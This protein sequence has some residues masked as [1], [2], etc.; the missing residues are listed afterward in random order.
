MS[1]SSS[2]SS[3]SAAAATVTVT[4]RD[5]EFSNYNSSTGKWGNAVLTMMIEDTNTPDNLNLEVYDEKV[6]AV[7]RNHDDPT[8]IIQTSAEIDGMDFRVTISTPMVASGKY[9]L[10][11][12][13]GET[14]HAEYA[15]S[16]QFYI[17]VP[18]KVWDFADD[19][20]EE[21]VELVSDWN[22][23]GYIKD[24]N[25]NI[26]GIT[27][28]SE[29]KDAVVSQNDAT[30]FS[31]DGTTLTRQQVKGFKMTSMVDTDLR[32]S[33][34]QNPNFLRGY[35]SLEELDIVSSKV[36]VLMRS[37]NDNFNY[38]NSTSHYNSCYG[39]S[40][41]NFNQKF[42]YPSTLNYAI[43]ET[44]T[45]VS[46]SAQFNKPVYLGDNITIVNN[47]LYGH[48][49][50]TIFN[51]KIRFSP[52]L[53]RIVGGFFG[54]CSNLHLDTV[55]P[56]SNNVQ[57]YDISDYW[58][59]LGYAH[60]HSYFNIPSTWTYVPSNFIK[61]WNSYDYDINVPEGITEIHSGAISNLALSQS[62]TRTITLPSTLTSCSGLEN[63]GRTTHGVIIDLSKCN[64][65]TSLNSTFNWTG[66]K[67]IKWPTQIRFSSLPNTFMYFGTRCFDVDPNTNT[68]TFEVP[69]GITRIGNQ[70]CRQ[71]QYSNGDA[72]TVHNI[73]LPSTLTYI[74]ASF[75]NWWYNTFQAKSRKMCIDMTKIDPDNITIVDN[76]DW[77]GIRTGGGFCMDSNDH[78]SHPGYLTVKVAPGTIEKWQEKLPDVVYEYPSW[79]NTSIFSRIIT[80]VETP[81]PYGYVFYRETS[82]GPE[83][84]VELQSLAEFNS[85]CFTNY[86]QTVTVGED[87]ITLKNSAAPNMITGFSIGTDITSLPD[88]FGENCRITKVYFQPS[89]NTVTAGDSCFFNSGWDNNHTATINLNN[90]VTTI[91]NDFLNQHHYVSALKGFGGVTSVGGS[92]LIYNNLD[93]T[94]D[95][96]SLV[97]VGSN[98]LYNCAN[99]N[100]QLD[101][102]S[103]TT[104][105]GSF[106]ERCTSYNQPLSLPNVTSGQMGYFL[107]GC[108]SFNQPLDLSNAT[109]IMYWSSF[110]SGCTSFN[111]AITFPSSVSGSGYKS[112]SNF[113]WNCT[114]FNQPIDLSFLQSANQADILNDCTV[115]NS[116]ITLP[117]S[118]R[119]YT[120][121]NNCV[122]FN[123]PLTLPTHTESGIYGSICKNLKSF[124]Q[125][126]TI[127]ST[128]CRTRWYNSATLFENCDSLTSTVTISSSTVPNGTDTAVIYKSFSTTDSTAPCYTTGV[129]FTGTGASAWKNVLPDYDGTQ[130]T[131]ADTYRKINVV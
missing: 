81:T 17:Q 89:A 68:T 18:G 37:Y 21:D 83:K 98:F 65:L 5:I 102:S 2:S 8:D 96:S 58:G 129:T 11:K 91:G 66:I 53:S 128:L 103:L 49:N 118:M 92:F 79:A 130:A 56:L 108:T 51:S 16:S 67:E 131:P 64:N 24:V 88:N 52:N 84:Y 69:E 127:P 114:S 1:S 44:N 73:I 123:Q 9:E 80:W 99:F 71:C 27:S 101:F 35:D 87:Q 33:N 60:I 22:N 10:Y 125:P 74:D 55:Y 34:N 121:L 95:T 100:S 12:V 54:S 63:N 70:F 38:A 32:A 13:Y 116:S 82:D 75:N 77:N 113:M 94:F 86:G 14:S 106:L 104:I 39:I 26:Y 85:L 50:K 36:T 7:F 62:T 78:R 109:G 110:L 4:A 30:E 19:T 40:S 93:L 25:D 117:S 6:Y 29:M 3:S 61:Y 90:R 28:L 97:S 124:N 112:A 59:A 76:F 46:G 41:R 105:G 20:V 48:N 122:N 45:P 42:A 31:V 115:F 119:M 23:Y 57:L 111:S 107:Y 120:L 15:T 72:N 43:L 47:M 126:I